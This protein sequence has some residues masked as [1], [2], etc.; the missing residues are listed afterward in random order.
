MSATSAA[1]RDAIGKLSKELEQKLEDAG[2]PRYQDEVLALIEENARVLR[3]EAAIASEVH[4]DPFGAI[5]ALQVILPCKPTPPEP[6]KVKVLGTIVTLINKSE[7]STVD[8]ESG[9]ATLKVGK[10]CTLSYKFK[11]DWSAK[12]FS[13]HVESSQH[14]TVRPIIEFT[15][16]WSCDTH[17][18]EEAQFVS[19][20][21]MGCSACEDARTS[22]FHLSLIEPSH[23][24]NSVA[25]H[26]SD[27]VWDEEE[28]PFW[29]LLILTILPA[30]ELVRFKLAEIL[31]P[32][33]E[34]EDEN[35][36]EDEEDEDLA[37]QAF[38]KTRL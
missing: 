21:E 23:V 37:D 4:E 31:A 16:S 19:E 9:Q 27:R 2:A 10:D 3:T 32:P 14:G 34:S 6:W 17:G 35:E 1:I 24:I 33:Q 8:S 7:E 15:T 22:P 18:I 36:D 30:P 5:D 20:S 12:K 38:K 11:H 13:V 26:L 25:P 28:I 29:I